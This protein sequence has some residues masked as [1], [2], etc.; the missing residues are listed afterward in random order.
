MAKTLTRSAV[1]E[2]ARIARKEQAGKKLVYNDTNKISKDQ[3][4][5][6]NTESTF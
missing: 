6:W 3:N 4:K 2:Q 5:S 1:K